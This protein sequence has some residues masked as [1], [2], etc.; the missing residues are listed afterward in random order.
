MSTTTD[1]APKPTSIVSGAVEAFI[2]ENTTPTSADLTDAL[3]GPTEKTKT[4]L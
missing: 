2:R 1:D 4:L 3:A